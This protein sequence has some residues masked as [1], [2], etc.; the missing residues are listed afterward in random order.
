MVTI[1]GVPAAALYGQLL[2]GLI[3][4]SFYA[5]LSLGLAVI[6]GM[7]NVI[8]VAHGAMYMLGAFAAWFLLHMFG[9]SYW[10]ALGLAPI[11]VALVGVV[12]ERT[13]L[14]R[15]AHLDHL[16]GFLLTLGLAM[17]IEGLFRYW[18][19][20]SGQPYAIP[21]ALAGGIKLPFMFLPIYRV[22]VVVVSLVVCLATWLVIERT[23]IGAHLRAATENAVLSQAF[24]LN[25]PL[26]VTLTYAG[27][28][29]LAGLA[30]VLAAPIYQ[31]SP[32]MGSNLI[33]VVFA[34][35][36]VGGMGSILGSIVT[37]YLLGIVEGMTRVYY[38]EASSIVIFVIMVVVLM[39]RPAGLFGRE[40]DSAANASPPI[41]A[42]QA[43]GMD[44]K[45]AAIGA[46]GVVAALI[47]APALVYPVFLMK[48]MCFAL[49]A[50]AFNLL[51]GFVGLLS[52]GHAAFFGSGAYIAAYAA[53]VWHLDPLLCVLAGTA[54]GAVLGLLFGALAIRRSGIYF[55][56]ITLALAQ[57]VYFIALQAPF[58]GGEDGIQD[59]PRGMLFGVLDLQHPVA[60]YGFVMAVFV[61]GMAVLWRVVRSPFG[62]VLKAIRENEA[63]AIS[64]GYDVQRF[65]LKAFVISAALAGAAGGTKALVFQLAS[66]T[67]VTWQMSGD[68]VLMTLMG[69]IGTMLGPV[70]GAA[71]VVS[72]ENALAG[73]EFPITVLIGAIFIACVL[74]F[75]RGIVGEVQQW[76]ARLSR[77][78][79]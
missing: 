27:G 42:T 51:I 16:Y 57:M 14:R 59:V 1:F 55:A 48:L 61:V 29:A 10:W 76:F 19:G 36:V 31:V 40:K 23:H 71:V 35:V 4:G 33:I 17:V 9:I 60:M 7:L 11:A 73:L 3:N 22:W 53:K 69:G 20:S 2:V 49:F 15:V 45:W 43:T 64:L 47:A 77:V 44:D 63:R 12:I 52:F 68:V 39:L 6:F 38:P 54:T 79:N 67:D 30:G 34:V 56:M 70:V 46:L 58:T 8:N 32:L 75:R 13:T 50:A 66:L 5:L 74:L 18:Y 26:L 78:S 65:K 21:S 41:G 72:L 62:Q 28:V 25:V 24:G 37:G